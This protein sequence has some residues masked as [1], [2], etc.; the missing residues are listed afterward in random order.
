MPLVLETYGFMGEAARQWL[1]YVALR[2]VD[3]ARAKGHIAPDYSTLVRQYY[4]RVAAVNQRCNAAIVR[5]W[6]RVCATAP[7]K[8]GVRRL[9]AVGA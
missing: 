6:Q 5:S 9:A 7:A 3:G 2:V 8:Y 1:R 4:E